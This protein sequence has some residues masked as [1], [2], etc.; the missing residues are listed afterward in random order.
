MVSRNTVAA[1]SPSPKSTILEHRRQQQ[2]CSA[3]ICS[4]YAGRR[5]TGERAPNRDT[6]DILA[7]ILKYTIQY[8]KLSRIK[9]AAGT[10]KYSYTKRFMML[11]CKHGLL[12]EYVFVKR[13]R[14]KNKYTDRRETRA[15]R[16]YYVT[17][18]GYAFLHLY[19]TMVSEL[20]TLEI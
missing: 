5:Y 15:I 19:D 4:L 11:L 2:Q 1:T 3:T 14:F 10:G 20:T 7:D 9:F 12:T 18:K 8:S 6:V 17:Q 16:R 13:C